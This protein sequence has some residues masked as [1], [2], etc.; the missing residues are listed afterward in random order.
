MKRPRF[1]YLAITM[2]AV[3]LFPFLALNAREESADT[4]SWNEN[5][6]EAVQQAR[7]EGKRVLVD[8]SGSDWCHWCKVM[9]SEVLS[10][11]EFKAYADKHLVLVLVDMP[12]NRPQT[13]AIKAQNKQLVNRF[14]VDGFPTFV[15]LDTNGNEIDRRVGYVSGGPSNFISFLR[16]TESSEKLD[17]AAKE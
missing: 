6:A 13:N 17:S 14:H 4:A 9:E 2:L 7:T 5:Y 16:V 1:P 12:A 10:K 8:F 11:P 3:M 15:V